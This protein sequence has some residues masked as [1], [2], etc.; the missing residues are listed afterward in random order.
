MEAAVAQ[1]AA[2][3]GAADDAGRL[4]SKPDVS[5]ERRPDGS[6]VIRSRRELGSVPRCVGVW[7]ERWAAAEPNRVF[8]AERDAAGGWRTHHLRGNVARRQRRCASR[9]S[10]A[11]WDPTARC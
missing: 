7:L 6:I 9:C 3:A 4:F 8:L 10:I 11:G 5:H 1:A 2:S